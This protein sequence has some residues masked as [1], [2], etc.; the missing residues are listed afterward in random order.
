[1]TTHTKRKM[2]HTTL[3]TAF[4]TSQDLPDFWQKC[5]CKTK[6]NNL[7]ALFPHNINNWGNTNSFKIILEKE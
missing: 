3:I 1:M 2:L 4:V 6:T 7:K 5:K